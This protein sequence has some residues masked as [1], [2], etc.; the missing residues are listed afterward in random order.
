MT[1]GLSGDKKYSYDKKY[2]DDKKYSLLRE[3]FSMIRGTLVDKKW[4]HDALPAE[5]NFLT[6]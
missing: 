1:R 6:L 3:V 5:I 2:S 4:S